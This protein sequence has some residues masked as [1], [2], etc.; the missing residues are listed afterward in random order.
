MKSPFQDI[1][2]A[3][4]PLTTDKV[5]VR[6]TRGGVVLTEEIP[7]CVLDASTAE[8]MD[9]GSIGSGVQSLSFLFRGVSPVEMEFLLDLRP[10]DEIHRPNPVGARVY[11]ITSVD[12]DR[13][14]GVSV[15]ARERG[16]FPR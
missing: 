11:A 15:V 8:M 16:G 10:G 4:A 12:V 6:R 9:D 2:K 14:Q 5:V 1:E 3:Y 13:W 7:C